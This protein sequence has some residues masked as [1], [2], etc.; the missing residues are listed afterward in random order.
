MTKRNKIIYFSFMIA[1]IVLTMIMCFL[2]NN[3]ETT[4]SSMQAKYPLLGVIW[5][6]IAAIAVFVNLEFLR[7]SSHIEKR[8]F[9]NLIGIGSFSVILTPFTLPES[10]IGFTL[11][12]IDIHLLSAVFF[13]ASCYISLMVILYSH[14]GK[15]KISYYTMSSILLVIAIV[16]IYSII[17][18]GG[19]ITAP[20]EA[21]LLTAGLTVLFVTNFVIP[22]KDLKKMNLE[23]TGEI[24]KA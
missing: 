16:T 2:T 13:A 15:H 11:S 8:W 7:K 6:L 20:L 21:L 19:Y 24:N 12:F 14:R 1:S 23:M 4:I 22:E 3:E 17:A 10:P 5:S 18:L 9:K